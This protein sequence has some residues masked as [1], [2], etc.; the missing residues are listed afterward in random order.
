MRIH[1]LGVGIDNVT[2]DQALRAV[3]RRIASQQPTVIYTPNPIMIHQA[4]QDDRFRRTLNRAALN[5]PDGIGLLLAARLMGLPLTERVAGIEFGQ[6]LLALAARKKLRVFLL[7]A[8]PGTAEQAARNLQKQMPKLTVCGTYHG[9]FKQAESPEICRKIE[10]ARTDILLVCLGSPAQ[11]IWIDTHHPKGVLVSVALGGS[12]DVWAGRVMRAPR[13]LSD[14][15]LEWLWRMIRE[16]HRLAKL[17]AIL[18]FL[19]AARQAKKSGS[20]HSNGKPQN[21]RK[22]L[23]CPDGINPRR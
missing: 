11:E 20:P 13:L 22:A 9:Y 5:L 6:E 12:L 3:Q 21:L 10:N 14:L 18:E 16:P 23:L 19:L 2:R 17:P 8:T 15:G 4:M 1:M 7:G